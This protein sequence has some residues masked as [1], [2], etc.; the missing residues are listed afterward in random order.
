M[1]PRL[2]YLASAFCR[3]EE[4]RAVRDRL[5]TIG[6]HVTSTWH[7]IEGG[8]AKE[9]SFDYRLD[10]DTEWCASFA[11]V[12]LDCMSAAD[13]VISFTGG[14]GRGGR[15]VEFGYGL[16][17]N[18]RLIV[19]GPREHVFHCLSCVDVYSDVDAMLSAMG[20]EDQ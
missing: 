19:V 5:T 13:T 12:D 16:A 9:K 4:M 15:H 1:T 18:Q 10:T 14:G 6:H 2:V 20:G 7:D 17:H 11:Q 8:Q 3:A